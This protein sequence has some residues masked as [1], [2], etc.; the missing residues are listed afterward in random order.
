MFKWETGLD[1]ARRSFETGRAFIKTTVYMDVA[2][3]P[4]LKA[5]FVVSGMIAGK[6]HVM[7]A[8]CPPNL[9][10][11]DDNL[12]FLGQGRQGGRGRRVF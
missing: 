1:M 7:V 5:G 11:S 8:T 2:K 6:G 12:L 3:L 9:S 10:V 4:V